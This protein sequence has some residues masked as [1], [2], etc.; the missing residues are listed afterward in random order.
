MNTSE[1]FQHA[2][3][4]VEAVE[5][6]LASLDE[7]QTQSAELTAGIEQLAKEE[8]DTLA[9]NSSE[10]SKVKALL[11]L[12]TTRDVK[13]ASLATVKADIA[14]TKDEITAAGVAAYRWTEAIVHGLAE[15]RKSRVL[16]HLK[17]VFVKEAMSEVSRFLPYAIEVKTVADLQYW[18]CW[19]KPDECLE[20][21][22]K[23]RGVFDKLTAF[24]GEESDDLDFIV[25]ESWL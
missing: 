12:R 7:L 8:S 10:E 17:T 19:V 9:G 20:N 6:K 11:K 18:A 21:A 24:A 1:T 25:S 14:A 16:E 2:H 15:S 13:A 3:N 23:I 5:S 22:G 4:A